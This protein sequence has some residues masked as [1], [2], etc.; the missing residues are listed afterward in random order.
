[1]EILILIKAILS[2]ISSAAIIPVVGFWI[3]VWFQRIL[4]FTSVT[5]TATFGPAVFLTGVKDSAWDNF[6][7]NSRNLFEYLSVSFH[8]WLF[9]DNLIPKHL[10]LDEAQET[11]DLPKWEQDI[12][13]SPTNP[14]E[15]G[16]ISRWDYIEVPKE[17]PSVPAKVSWLDY[18]PTLPDNLVAEAHD[19]IYNNAAWI[20]GGILVIG[21]TYFL[22]SSD[23]GHDLA[24]SIK[25]LILS[26]WDD[27]S[28]PDGGGTVGT[29]D[30]VAQAQTSAGGTLPSAVLTQARGLDNDIR[31]STRLLQE[32]LNS[33][34][35]LLR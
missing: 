2:F 5:F 17:L 28:S 16:T 18:M 11:I 34:S 23:F 32:S 31:T 35:R 29:A 7:T 3:Y 30:S 4:L 13:F 20:G 21:G 27:D 33:P 14:V 15:K 6:T 10:R 24:N 12:H 9:N 1:M 8:N 22:L 25:D 26:Y 19:S